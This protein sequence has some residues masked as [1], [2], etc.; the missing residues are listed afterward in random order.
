M[1]R[2]VNTLD[3]QDEKDYDIGAEFRGN[4]YRIWV[5]SNPFNNVFKYFHHIPLQLWASNIKIGYLLYNIAN[6][7]RYSYFFSDIKCPAWRLVFDYI[8]NIIVSNRER[9]DLS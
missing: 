6:L 5:I 4:I 1:W 7:F 8:F 2:Y 9:F 3:A